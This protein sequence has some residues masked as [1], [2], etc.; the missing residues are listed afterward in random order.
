MKQGYSRYDYG[1]RTGRYGNA[2]LAKVG[3]VGPPDLER[4]MAVPCGGIPAILPP[5]YQP[6]LVLGCY[7]QVT[8]I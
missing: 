7:G 8:P 5:G 2:L 4:G 1:G 3:A 6:M